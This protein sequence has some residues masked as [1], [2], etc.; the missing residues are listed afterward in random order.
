VRSAS[1]YLLA[2]LLAGAGLT[3]FLKPGFY[4][5]IVP[6]ALPG[7]ARAWTYGSGVVELAVAAAVAAPRTR[8][9]GALVAAVLFVAV[10][11]ANIQMAVDASTWG[12]RRS[13]TPGCRCRS[14][15]WSGP[16]GSAAA[17]RDH[18]FD[19]DSRVGHHRCCRSTTHTA[20][21]AAGEGAPRAGRLFCVCYWICDCVPVV[22]HDRSAVRPLLPSCAVPARRVG[23]GQ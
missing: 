21:E 11:P 6:H 16:G 8:S 10:Y 13:R 19:N 1:P 4:D 15:W 18:V 12:R 3:H 7:P 5:P 9:R 17:T 2:A 23:G 14:H 20:H 22:L